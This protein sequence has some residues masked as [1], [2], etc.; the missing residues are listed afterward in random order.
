MAIYSNKISQYLL[1]WA[2]VIYFMW[3]SYSFDIERLCIRE[4]QKNVN[5][6]KIT[7]K[8]SNVYS[9]KSGVQLQ[10]YNNKPPLL[11]YP[12]PCAVDV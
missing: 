10:L 12:K 1:I 9:T 4:S 11:G 5:L 3:S 7:A 6:H 2:F 8:S